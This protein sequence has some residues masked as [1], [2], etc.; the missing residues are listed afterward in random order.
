MNPRAD[1][2]EAEENMREGVV[3]AGLPAH[4][5]SK[6]RSRAADSQDNAKNRVGMPLPRRPCRIWTE[7]DV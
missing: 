1:Q 4:N 7:C 3:L 2:E 6:A 5:R